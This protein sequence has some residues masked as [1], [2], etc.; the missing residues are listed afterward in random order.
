MSRVL[1]I[2]GLL[3]MLYS[4]AKGQVLLPKDTTV[5]ATEESVLLPLE[6]YANIMYN[7]DRLF[8]LQK[9]IPAYKNTV[10]SLLSVDSLKTAHYKQKLNNKDQQLQ[11][12]GMSKKKAVHR[13]YELEAINSKKTKVIKILGG[14]LVVE[15]V[16]GGLFLL[17]K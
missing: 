10:D 15:T 2:V 4:F 12:E 7:N 8:K 14:V 9:K 17:L 16:M 6:H 1:F 5:T 13:V 3:C 11:Y